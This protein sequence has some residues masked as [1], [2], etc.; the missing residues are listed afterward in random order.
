MSGISVKTTPSTYLSRPNRAFGRPVSCE[1]TQRLPMDL[2]VDCALF[3]FDGEALKLLLIQQ[4]TDVQGPLS[5]EDLQM[6]LPGDFVHEHEALESA[7]ERVLHELTGLHNVYLKQFHAFGDPDRVKGLKDQHWLRTFRANPENRVVTVAYFGL[8]SLHDHVPQASSFAGHAEWV[9]VGALPDLAFDH[10]DIADLAVATLREQLESKHIG[11]EMLP[12][13]FTLRQL[14]SLHEIVLD[15]KL[16][17]R[18]FRKNIKRMDH[19]VPLDEKEQ[20]VLHKPAQLFTFDANLT[21]ES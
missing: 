13:K 18:N 10:N 7:A 20:G 4:R 15:K 11:F 9:D 5:E 1:I 6:A 16:D 3:G 21:T 17:K 19:V 12:K 8:V 14:Q 2:S